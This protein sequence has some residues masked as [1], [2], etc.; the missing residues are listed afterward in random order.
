MSFDHR[1]DLNKKKERKKFNTPTVDIHNT[2][3]SFLQYFCEVRTRI[4]IGNTG[5]LFLVIS[6]R[7]EQLGGAALVPVTARPLRLA[8]PLPLALHG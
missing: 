1:L 6:P 7:C 3:R 2:I 4:W 8:G 5:Q